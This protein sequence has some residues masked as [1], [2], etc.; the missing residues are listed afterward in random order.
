MNKEELQS[1]KNELEK[2]AIDKHIA[3]DMSIGAGT[4]GGMSVAQDFAKKVFKKIPMAGYKSRAIENA[5][6]GAATLGILGYLRKRYNPPLD[7]N[8]FKR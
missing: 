5:I 1:F 8:A 4:F 6:A 7:N 3:K 2:I